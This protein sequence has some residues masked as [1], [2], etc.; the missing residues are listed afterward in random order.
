L[1]K[2]K[3]EIEKI[4]KKYG[5]N[6][7]AML[8][9]SQYGNDVYDAKLTARLLT[10]AEQNRFPSRTK[11]ALTHAECLIN[12]GRPHDAILLI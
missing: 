2:R 4:I 6:E 10:S 12:A 1:E 5:K 11:F 3:T 7:Q 8:E 9:L